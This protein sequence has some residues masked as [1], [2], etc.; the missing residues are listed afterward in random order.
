MMRKFCTDGLKFDVIFID[1]D[2]ES[3]LE[4]Y[5]LSINHLLAEDGVIL[6]DNS[7]SALTFQKDDAR[8]PIL[9]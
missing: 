4:Y 3:Y 6:V 1:A 9:H 5:N 2:K 7:L 8:R